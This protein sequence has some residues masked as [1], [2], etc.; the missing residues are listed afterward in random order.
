MNTVASYYNKVLMCNT[1]PA[2]LNFLSGHI[3]HAIHQLAL[4][5]MV[6]VDSSCFFHYHTNDERT[7]TPKDSADVSGFNTSV[8][9]SFINATRAYYPSCTMTMS[10]R[11]IITV[12]LTYHVGMVFRGRRVNFGFPQTLGQLA[13]AGF[14]GVWRWVRRRLRYVT[15]PEPPPPP[16]NPPPSRCSEALAQMR[17]Q[18]E[19]GKCRLNPAFHNAKLLCSSIMC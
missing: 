2:R 10:K 4:Y 17:Q 9:I 16:P 3:S 1:T 13:L 5:L 7:H 15:R 12:H 14:N 11:R 6:V 18:Q 19:A 8:R